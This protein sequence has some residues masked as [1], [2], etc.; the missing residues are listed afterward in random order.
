MDS[1]IVEGLGKR[2]YLP[3]KRPS[4]ASSTDDNQGAGRF[5]LPRMPWRRRLDPARE[6]WALR[7]ISFRV[8]PGTI[9]GVIGAN[10]AGKSTLLKIVARVTRPTE[11]R[12]VGFGRVVSLLELGA[13]FN[14]DFSAYDN[15]LMNAAMHGIA[16]R[17][18]LDRL[19]DI[20]SF[21]E[22]GEFMDNPLRQ[23]S[24]GMY[25]RLAFSVAINMQP[26]ILLADEILAVGDLAFQARCL[27]RVALEAERGLTV[28][29][30]SHDMS[31]LSRLCQRTIWIDK[32]R[33]MRDGDP[34]RVIADYEESALGSKAGK[35]IFGDT[36]G[37]NTNVEAEIASVRLLNAA[38]EE[39]GAA[40]AGEDSY[41]RLRLK[42]RKAG[43]GVR[44]VVDVFAKGVFLF[45]AVQVDEFV[46]E[47]R[48]VVDLLARI[49]AHLLAETTYAVNAT[50]YTRWEK[51]SKIVL[52]N[53][54]TFMAYAE[55]HEAQFK[56]SVRSGVIA[57]R[58]DWQVRVHESV[59]KRKKTRV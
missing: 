51:E 45:R 39:V 26:D 36:A 50:V 57:P 15:I 16:R 46:S 48:G 49:P 3:S 43:R 32:G 11:G 56:S 27:E 10:G 2:Y 33:L 24:S 21:A 1:L 23:Y 59:A 14:P 52:T 30:V 9:L 18:A 38:G 19:P 53:A 54:L 8:E 47:R 40:Q 41:I 13:G 55:P 20:V 37:R 31:A 5:T 29:F 6:L 42:V 17:E 28:L 35:Q 12:V 4:D 7:D 34:E 22:L 25:L 58:L 44:G